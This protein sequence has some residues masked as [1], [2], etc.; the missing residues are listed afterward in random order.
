VGD[1][2]GDDIPES[3]IAVD[4]KPIVRRFVDEAVDGDLDPAWRGRE[5]ASVTFDIGPALTAP[6]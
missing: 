2:S 5:F 4:N 3:G 1:G 6:P